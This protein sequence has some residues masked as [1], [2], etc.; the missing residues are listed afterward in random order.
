MQIRTKTEVCSKNYDLFYQVTQ[1]KYSCASSAT[2]VEIRRASPQKL[3]G[4][5]SRCV[6][7]EHRDL[8]IGNFRSNRI[9][10]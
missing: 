7:N 2:R 3:Q 4:P 5:L 9:G 8:R 10:G 6:D 1:C